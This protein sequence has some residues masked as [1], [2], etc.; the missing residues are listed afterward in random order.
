[1]TGEDPSGSDDE[2]T[3]SI[4]KQ[5]DAARALESPS[6]PRVQQ[7]SQREKEI[8]G[9]RQLIDR[10]LYITNSEVSGG[11]IKQSVNRPQGLSLKMRVVDTKT[12]I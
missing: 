12:I 11:Q 1:M 7:A 8:E 3:N 2:N 9:T 10:G 4:V 6:N 5:T